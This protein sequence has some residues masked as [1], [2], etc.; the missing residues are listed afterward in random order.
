MILKV[1]FKKMFQDS[2]CVHKVMRNEKNPKNES[3][4]GSQFW[5]NKIHIFLN[6]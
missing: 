2:Y 4:V 1:Y 5:K 3:Q 6:T